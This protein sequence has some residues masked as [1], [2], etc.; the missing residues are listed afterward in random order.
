MA[1]RTLSVTTPT[2]TG[3]SVA[4]ISTV[5]ASSDTCVI[6]PTTAQSSLDFATLALRA[7]NA[8][9]ITSVILTI[10][11]GTEFS[12][13]GI[14]TAAVTVGTA[15][16]VVIGGQFFESSRFQ[17]SGGT[18]ILTAAGTGPTSIEAYQKPQAS[19]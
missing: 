16:T 14:G 15:E 8:N 17:T 12:D 10:G 4:S 6:S 13:I 1:A 19:E 18:V 11:V 7:T 9:T 5:M 3:A 2:L